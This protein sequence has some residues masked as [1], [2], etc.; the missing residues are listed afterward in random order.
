MF[1]EVGKEGRI[2]LP[3][4]IRDRNNIEEKTRIIVRE[5]K[6]EIILTPVKKYREPTNALL[7][8]LPLEEPLDEPKELARR[9]VREKA[10]ERLDSCDS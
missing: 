5:R 10:L 6:G 7:G 8:S 2:V 4:D 1:V 3:K 9:H